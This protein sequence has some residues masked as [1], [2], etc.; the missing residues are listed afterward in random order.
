[1]DMTNGLNP[2]LK[3]ERISLS[4]IPDRAVSIAVW[5]SMNSTK[6][7]HDV[8]ITQGPLDGSGY[9]LRIVDGKVRWTVGTDNGETIFDHETKAVVIPETLWTSIIASYVKDTGVV[10]IFVNGVSKLTETVEIG[11]RKLLPRDWETEA[12]LGDKS[13][14]GYMDEF[15]IYNWGVDSSEASYIRNYCADH[16]KLVRFTVRVPLVKRNKILRGKYNNLLT[17]S[18]KQLRDRLSDL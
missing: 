6:G 9:R 5:V 14:N 17:K 4:H 8:F 15:I 7:T 1:M 13:F 10:A 3:I 2:T 18:A 12:K 11:Q 16:P